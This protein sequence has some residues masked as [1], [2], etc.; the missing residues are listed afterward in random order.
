MATAR[1]AR[2]AGAVFAASALL[3]GVSATAASAATTPDA[4][5]PNTVNAPV[6][7]ADPNSVTAPNGAN[8]RNAD[9]SKISDPDVRSLARS[10]TRSRLH[11]ATGQ[12][13]NATQQDVN[14]DTNAV[15]KPQA[16]TFQSAGGY[17]FASNDNNVQM[18]FRSQP[19][20]TRA[21]SQRLGRDGVTLATQPA[22][23]QYADSGVVVPLGNVASVFDRSQR[24]RD[25]RIVGSD[26]RSAS[27][28]LFVDNNGDGR[29]L[30]VAKNGTMVSR[31][32]DQ[33]LVNVRAG[34]TDRSAVT[35]RD[36]AQVWAWV[37]VGGNTA[38]SATIRSINGR[39]LVEASTRLSRGHWRPSVL[40]IDN[41]CRLYHHRSENMWVVHNVSGGRD[42]LF[43]VGVTYH[44][45]T[46]WTGTRE[47]KAY[48]ATTVVTS[49]GGLATLVYWDGHSHLR[50][51]FA[52]SNHNL[53][54]DSDHHP[55]HPHH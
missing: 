39:S 16:T 41:V 28:N 45:V 25:L 17:Q 23:G 50:Y 42:R 18:R 6:Q 12:D 33:V 32:V 8:V 53:Y 36:D 51:D 7:L 27:I 20:A 10:D 21:A 40:V 22:R 3:V 37:G 34:V 29:Y 48:Q 31:G 44:N 13:T 5:R 19:I 47:V 38:Q 1:L 14:A 54:C 30:N 52:V 26:V 15:I 2:Y 35:A 11:M 49:Y 43:H 46:T 24:L 4:A 55:H 9:P